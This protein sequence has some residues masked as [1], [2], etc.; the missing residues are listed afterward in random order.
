M[1]GLDVI[2]TL[3]D[4][5]KITYKGWGSNCYLFFKDGYIYNKNNN[6]IEKFNIKYF[7]F[8]DNNYKIYEDKQE[9]VRCIDCKHIHELLLIDFINDNTRTINNLCKLS[10][11]YTF[12]NSFDK[13]ICEKFEKTEYKHNLEDL[14][15]EEKYII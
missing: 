6:G 5:K 8:N 15:N 14:K 7:N 12:I 10:D 13:K 3:L 9:F 2:K 11:I 1:K 4:G